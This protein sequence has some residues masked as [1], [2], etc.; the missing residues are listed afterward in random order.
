MLKKQP[1]KVF[2]T[3]YY[4][5]ASFVIFLGAG[6]SADLLWGIADIT[7]GGMALINMPVILILGKYAIRALDD[8]IS[9]S[10]QGKE[11]QFHVSSINLPHEVDYWE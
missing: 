6:L 11:P 8:F 3:V 7:M 2:N 4:I 10:K 1:S 5:L 9:Q